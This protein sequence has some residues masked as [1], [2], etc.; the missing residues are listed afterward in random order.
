MSLTAGKATCVEGVV[1]V[2]LASFSAFTMLLSN[3]G[4]RV[5]KTSKR[6]TFFNVLSLIGEYVLDGKY[7]VLYVIVSNLI[8]PPTKADRNPQNFLIGVIHRMWTVKPLY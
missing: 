2:G 3:S 8:I 1:I 5:T 7:V 4:N 6:L